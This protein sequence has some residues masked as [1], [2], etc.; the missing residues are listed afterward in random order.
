MEK[1]RRSWSGDILGKG[2][3]KGKKEL[4][5]RYLGKERRKRNEGGGEEIFWEREMEKERR[6][7]AGDILGK[8][9]GKGKKELGMRYLGKEIWKRKEGAGQE[10]GQEIFGE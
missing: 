8:R 4:G 1:E 6:S 9:D 2:D 3:R 7:L 10:T 5:R